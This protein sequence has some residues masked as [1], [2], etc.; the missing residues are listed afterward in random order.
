MWNGDSIG[1]IIEQALRWNW[2]S[3]HATSYMV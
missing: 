3:F 1:Q 2:R